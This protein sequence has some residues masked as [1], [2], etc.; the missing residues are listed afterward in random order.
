MTEVLDKHLV[1]LGDS[2]IEKRP[3]SHRLFGR[4]LLD[5]GQV[6]VR[7]PYLD[8]LWSR[9]PAIVLYDWNFSP[10]CGRLLR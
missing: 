6:G 7:F 10:M 5:M 2:T 8:S 3:F 1:L 9:I 4:S